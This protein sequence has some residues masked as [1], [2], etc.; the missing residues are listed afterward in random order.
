MQKKCQNK[1]KMKRKKYNHEY[2]SNSEYEAAQQLHKLK[3]DFS[4]PKEKMLLIN[5]ENPQGEKKH[6]KLWNGGHAE[7]TVSLYKRGFFKDTL[8]ETFTGNLAGCEYGAH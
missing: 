1:D 8:I 6:D 4:C 2:K 7:G 5:Y 3:I